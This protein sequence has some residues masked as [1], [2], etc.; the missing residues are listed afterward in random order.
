MLNADGEAQQTVID[1]D[2]IADFHRNIGMGLHCRIGHQR[3]HTAQAL[4][5]SDQT[6]MAQERLHVSGVFYLE[7]EDSGI[8]GG[9]AVLNLVARMIR[10]PRMEDFTDCRMLQQITGNDQRVALMPLHAQG[11]GLHALH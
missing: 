6:D 1:T 7:G 8:A 2:R 3:F 5:E 4:S 11:Q 10:Q 9:L